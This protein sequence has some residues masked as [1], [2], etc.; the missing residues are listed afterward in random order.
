[1]KKKI[2][3]V[4]SVYN[5]QE[6]LNLFVNAFEKIKNKIQW[7]YE[8]IFVN[9]GSSDNSLSILKELSDKYPYIKLISFTKNFGHEAAMIAGIDNATGDGIICM[10]ADL[11]HPVECIPQIISEFDK[12]IDVVNMIRTENKSAGLSKKI[13]TFLFYRVVNIL[14]ANDSFKE[15]ASDFIAISKRA[16]D[17]LRKNY[18]DK[19]RFLRGYVQNMGFPSTT[20]TYV[21]PE[22][23]AGKS[24][25]SLIK[26]WHYSTNVIVGFS[27]FPLKVGGY[28]GIASALI[29]VLVIIDALLT[30]KKAPSGYATIIVVLCFMFAVLFVIIGI[31]GKYLAVLFY[32]SKDRPIYILDEKIGFNGEE[33]D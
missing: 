7:D 6:V 1:M 23:A 31:I 16:A 2:S 20:I 25:Y 9:D 11:Q 27:D 28:A 17:V 22:R 8:L 26:L 21:A 33:N 3:I 13:T 12:G 18:R 30:Y 32:E 24:H 10:D 29:G 4:V 5:E 15:N 19:V 14:S